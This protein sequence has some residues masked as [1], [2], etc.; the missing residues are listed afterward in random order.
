MFPSQEKNAK[1]ALKKFMK[2]SAFVGRAKS[3]QKSRMSE[4]TEPELEKDLKTISKSLKKA[5]YDIKVLI[6]NQRI[7]N[8]LDNNEIHRFISNT[9]LTQTEEI[10][11]DPENSP[12]KKK[13][14]VT[15][16]KIQEENEMKKKIDYIEKIR[17]KKVKKLEKTFTRKFQNDEDLNETKLKFTEVSPEKRTKIYPY[18][19]YKK[20]RFR[21]LKS[22]NELYIKT[23][24]GKGKEEQLEYKA[25]NKYNRSSSMVA[26]VQVDLKKNAKRKSNLNLT[27]DQIGENDAYNTSLE[28][29]EEPEPVQ[30]KR[31][32]E[33]ERLYEK[34]ESPHNA[35]RY[36]HSK[37]KFIAPPRGGGTFNKID[38]SQS[39]VSGKNPNDLESYVNYKESTT[40]QNFFQSKFDEPLKTD[41]SDD[42]RASFNSR[43]MESMLNKSNEL[44][45]SISSVK[46]KER[47]GSDAKSSESKIK[48]LTTDFRSSTESKDK[49]PEI[50]HEPTPIDAS[51]LNK[52]NF[53]QEQI[54]ESKNEADDADSVVSE[55]LRNDLE[56]H[57]SKMTESF[58]E[59]KRKELLAEK[60]E[61]Y[62]K[63]PQKY[64]MIIDRATGIADLNK[65]EYIRQ[66]AT[67]SYLGM[68]ESNTGSVLNNSGLLTP[69]EM[70]K[71]T[72]DSFFKKRISKPRGSRL[73]I[74]NT[75][76]FR[77]RTSIKR[78]SIFTVDG[79][80]MYPEKDKITKLMDVI[81][82]TYPDEVPG[83]KVLEM[84]AKNE[85]RTEKLTK[86]LENYREL[87]HLEAP[88]LLS[89]YQYTKANNLMNEE[90]QEESIA[91]FLEEQKMLDVNV[92]KIKQKAMKLQL[93]EVMN[94]RRILRHDKMY[95]VKF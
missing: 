94:R 93:R 82:N 91:K 80:R 14:F 25:P 62:T 26:Q 67:N 13:A 34:W 90:E 61:A 45:K 33:I 43:F 84:Q 88:I 79:Q 65:S 42:V 50:Q 46:E 18:T 51:Y 6:R 8:C 27:A 53:S 77:S 31:D 24:C 83:D 2:V 74:N 95:N 58:I 73:S 71:A 15:Q 29:G 39:D 30:I 66:M 60:I 40:Q 87:N 4:K 85:I 16:K 81:A 17:E 57:K 38:D 35:M 5:E 70:L 75:N 56:H 36:L 54:D 23:F 21:I 41:L 69:D 37:R 44:R 47:D 89:I 11:N 72:A 59:R 28:Q 1:T 12:L 10:L 19:T 64:E 55:E 86:L 78:T 22:G 68:K 48:L 9:E 32:P 20:N 63:T 52:F 49:L 92:V 76:A 7:S 3:L